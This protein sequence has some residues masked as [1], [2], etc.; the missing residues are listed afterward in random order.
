MRIISPRNIGA[1]VGLVAGILFLVLPWWQ[2]LALIAAILTGYLVGV[3]L[4][5]RGDV[6]GRLRDFLKRL[7]RR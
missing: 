1:V 3:Y 7:F 5:S 6:N 2:V 4:E